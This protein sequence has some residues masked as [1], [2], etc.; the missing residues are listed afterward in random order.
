[1]LI[2]TYSLRPHC[3]SCWTIYI[4]IYYRYFILPSRYKASNASY[5][6]QHAS[7][8]ALQNS[9]RSCN[10]VQRITF[11]SLSLS[12]QFV[13]PV[14]STVLQK[15][16]KNPESPQTGAQYIPLIDSASPGPSDLS[17]RRKLPQSHR[18]K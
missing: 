3:V 14:R 4:Y 18:D 17:V 6:I 9:L 16:T 5:L 7:I 1:M 10:V 2:K 11:L 8:D 15:R 13:L 12:L